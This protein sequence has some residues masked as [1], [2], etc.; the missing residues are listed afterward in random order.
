MGIL[1]NIRQIKSLDRSNLLGSVQQLWL[2]CQQTKE[3]LEEIKVPSDYKEVD[4]I[5][6]NGM[7]GSRLGSRVASAL[8]ADQLEIPFLFMGNYNLPKFVDK[9]TL[10]LLSSYSGNTEEVVNSADQGL[11]KQAKILVFAQNGKLAKLAK[12]K[13]LPGYYGF[14]P[15]HNPCNQPRM[16][17]GYQV[18]GIILLLSKCGLL[19][20]NQKEIDNLLEFLQKVKARYDIDVSLKENLAK[21]V[22]KR[23]H[24]KIPVLVAAEFLM[25][26]LHVW[27]NQTNENSKNFSVLFEI[28][29]LNHHLLEGMGFPQTN[30]KNLI[31][32][33]VKS[34]LYHPRNQRRI[35]VTKR[36]LDGYKI[37][38]VDIRLNGKTKLIQAFELIQF[39]SFVSFYLSML[40]TLDP[41]PIP[42]V[43][44]FKE[45]L[46]K[47]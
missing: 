29:E 9:K 27:K 28:P 6:T 30:P 35:E 39:G 2:Q 26:S 40:N 12:E 20:I 32:I 31:F 3:E 47:Y 5:L 16:S 7:G 13:N 41:S 44:Y 38:H 17:L 10:L 36:V 22:S 34:D 15:K 25:G 33:F 37:K 45:Q 24:E 18:L 11:K 42:W 4:C 43:D 23:I 1:D 8:F 46:K 14:V 21:K 19:S